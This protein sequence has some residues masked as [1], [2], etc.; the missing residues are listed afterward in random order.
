[1]V[2]KDVFFLGG[3]KIAKHPELKEPCQSDYGDSEVIY[4]LTVAV[5]TTWAMP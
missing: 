4:R 2:T 1:M 5:T 3:K